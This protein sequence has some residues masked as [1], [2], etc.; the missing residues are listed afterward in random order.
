MIAALVVANYLNGHARVFFELAGDDGAATSAAKSVLD[1]L[2]SMTADAGGGA[3]RVSRRPLYERLR[4]R[5][6]FKKT[7]ALDAPL[8]RLV[9]HNFVQITDG[10]TGERP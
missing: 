6:Q 7:A 5:K 2:R 4:S 8:E 10:P 3:F 9:L 1:E